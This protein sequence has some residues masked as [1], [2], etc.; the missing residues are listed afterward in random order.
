VN[1][2][3]IAAVVEGQG[4]VAAVPVLLGRLLA[5]IA[6]GRYVAVPRPHRVSRGA[7]A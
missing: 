1:H 5:E 6:P 4:E 2:S 3:T 7:T